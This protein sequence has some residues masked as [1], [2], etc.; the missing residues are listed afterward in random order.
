MLSNGLVGM[1]DY[2]SGG[3]VWWFRAVLAVSGGCDWVLIFVFFKGNFVSI[4]EL[5]IGGWPPPG[6]GVGG[7]YLAWDK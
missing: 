4:L 5:E 7:S 6:G 3:H 1:G 2:C